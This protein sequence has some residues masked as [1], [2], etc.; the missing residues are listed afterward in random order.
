[1]SDNTQKTELN[2]MI[3]EKM[4]NVHMLIIF[5]VCLAFGIVNFASGAAA[6]G[7][8]TLLM[9]LAVPAAVFFI[10]KKKAPLSLCGTILSQAQLVTIIL[11]SVAK[12]ELHYM[13][14]LMLASMS[15]A[16]IYYNH[17]NL[18]IHWAIMDAASLIGFIFRDVFCEGADMSY[19]IKGILGINIGAALICYLIKCIMGF[20][21]ASQKSHEETEKLLVQVNEQMGNTEKLMNNQNIVVAQIADISDKLGSSASL[22]EQISSALNSAADDQNS[23][24]G[25]IAAD[26]ASITDEAEK[27]MDESEKA[28]EAAHSSTNMLIENNNEVKNMVAAMDEITEAS[29]KIES[30]IKTI[31]DI[32]FQTNILALNAAVEA[33][34]AGAAGKGFAVVADEV[35]N[36]ATKSAEAASNT[37]ALIQTTIEAV[38]KGT[39][40]AG[41]VAK[42]MDDVIRLSEE[43]TEQSAAIIRLTESQAGSAR[44][45]DEKMQRIA[46]SAAG[47]VKTAEESAQIAHSVSEQVR[48]MNMIV[49]SISS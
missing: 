41:N 45:A 27:S 2:G 24:I 43:S 38:E 35:R 23:V 8:V 7:A 4:I 3:T 11:I 48:K 49:K 34:R 9:G 13:F 19:L 26:I 46:D 32:A 1:M 25:E 15:I 6:I 10:K 28:S 20:I 39:L 14:P 29:H 21:D 42:R 18:F 30:I 16:A 44:S 31:E 17:K 37:S 36:L 40:L 12:H 5:G 33:A 22:M 47:N